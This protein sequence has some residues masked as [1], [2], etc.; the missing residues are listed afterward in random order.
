M[1]AHLLGQGPVNPT[2]DSEKS[3]GQEPISS[4]SQTTTTSTKDV[5]HQQVLR[6]ER[7]KASHKL[8]RAV[9]LAQIKTSLKLQSIQTLLLLAQERVPPLNHVPPQLRSP[10]P[11]MLPMHT[12]G[13]AKGTGTSS[14][15]ANLR[16]ASHDWILKCSGFKGTH[17]LVWPDSLQA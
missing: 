2:D 13:S 10:L 12:G 4:T 9:M 3:P 5:L 6:D 8:R 11:T 16:D 7:W 17:F 1:P 15:D 14:P